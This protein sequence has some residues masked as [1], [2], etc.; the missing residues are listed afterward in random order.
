MRWQHWAGMLVVIFIGY[1]LGERFGG[2]LKAI[3]VIGQFT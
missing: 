2:K 1:W 3:P